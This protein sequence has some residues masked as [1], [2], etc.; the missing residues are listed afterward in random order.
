MKKSFVKIR[1]RDLLF[2]HIVNTYLATVIELGGESIAVHSEF[3]GFTVRWRNKAEIDEL[4]Q[5]ERIHAD[6]MSFITLPDKPTAMSVASALLKNLANGTC[7]QAAVKVVTNSWMVL[8]ELGDWD[9]WRVGARER[10]LRKYGTSAK[11][12]KDG[13]KNDT[14]EI[15][16]NS[17]ESGEEVPAH[18]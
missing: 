17:E 4:R 2:K 9:S 10:W 13:R 5:W 6:G 8:T 12:V 7:L 16:G 11:D 3:D 1:C 14:E 15:S 18:H